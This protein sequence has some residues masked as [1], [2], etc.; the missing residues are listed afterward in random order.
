MLALQSEPR[1]APAK[2]APARLP[3][4]ANGDLLHTTEFLRRYDRMPDVKK[5]ELIEGVVY[6]GS[7]V[8]VSHSQPDG[9]VILWLATYASRTPGVQALPNTTVILDSQNTVQPDS[10]LRLLPARNGRTQVTEAKLLSGPPEL[11]VEIAAS[12][13]SIDAHKKL[14]AY[15]RSGVAEYLLWRVDD[16]RLDWLHLEDEQYVTAQP[17]AA[18]ILRSRV[19][20]GLQVSVA[21][22]LAGDSA[23]VL[24]SL[25][26]G[27]A[28][29]AHAEFARSLTTK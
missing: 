4:L 22:L 25:Q 24:A 16:E 2:A 28:S 3:L 11:V 26:E 9:L 1:L 21:A 20:P 7:P 5:A 27:L 10:L 8:S 29:P 17:D 18:G 15:Q 13:A 19:F 14:A 12:S 6:M 23:A